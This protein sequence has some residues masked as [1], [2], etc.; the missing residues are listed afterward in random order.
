MRKGAFFLVL[1]LFLFW[2][3]PVGAQ[4]KIAGK[5]AVLLDARSGQILF[6]KAMDEKMHPASTTKI[7]TALIAIESGK[8]EETVTIGPNPPRVEGT[9]VY[10]EEGEK[11]KLRELVLAAL[12]HSAN[13]A[14]LA[15]AEYLAGSA[16]DFAVKMNETAREIGAL[17]SHFVNPHGLTEE[18]H[19]S[20]AYDL[21]LIGCYA[22]ENETFREYV[23]AKILDWEGKAWQTRLIN[24]NKMLWRYD[25]ADGIKTGYTS[26]AKSTIVASA[27]RENRRL[28]AVVLASNGN[29]LWEDAESLLDFGFGEYEM[30]ELANPATVAATV[31]ISEDKQL[32]LMPDREMFFSVPRNGDNRVEAQVVLKPLPEAVAKGEILGRLSYLV[33]GVEAGTVDLVAGEEVRKS[34]DPSSFLLKLG[35]GMFCIQLLWRTYIVNRRRKRLRIRGGYNSTWRNYQSY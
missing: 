25:G 24:I 7:L 31:E 29:A 18:N 22:M 34:F 17:N 33:N 28:V 14:A 16:Q 30:L 13:D 2:G 21:A 19:Y 5:S 20:T 23:Q 1:A 3:S 27:T 35:A 11:I 10:L 6:A 12:V 32:R 9:R 8:L 15:I 4:P 26:E